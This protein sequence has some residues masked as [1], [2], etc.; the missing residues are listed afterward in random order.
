MLDAVP[1]AADAWTDGQM[2]PQVESWFAP[3]A[4]FDRLNRVALDVV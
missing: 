3:R 4:V 1:P 2:D